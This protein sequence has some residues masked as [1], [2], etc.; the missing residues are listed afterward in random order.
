MTQTDVPPAPAGPAGPWTDAARMA[1]LISHRLADPDL[2]ATA[3]RTSEQA[4]RYPFA[5]GGAS[6][7]SG[8]AGI[9]LLFRHAARVAGQPAGDWSVL[10]HRELV[11]AVASTAEQPLAE[12]GLAA[13]TA[14]LALVVVDAARTDHRYSDAA[15]STVDRLVRQVVDG[16]SWRTDDG[17]RDSDY[18]VIVGAAGTLSY[19]GRTLA[20]DDRVEPAVARLVDDLI[21]LCGRGD[22]RPH[23]YIPPRHYPSDDYR[24]AFP[25]GYVNMGLAHGLPGVLAA[26]SI[27]RAGGYRRPGLGT[28]IRE[29]ADYVAGAATFDGHGPVWGTGVAVDAS[30]TELP[31]RPGAAQTAWCYGTPGVA[32]ALLH[33]ATALD[34]DGLRRRA[35]DAFASVLTRF[36]D[37][38]TIPSATL[39]HGAAGLLMICAM[40]AEEGDATA[41]AALPALTGHLLTHCDPELPLGVR[42]LEQPGV[43]LDSPGLLSGAAGVALALW[44][45]GAAADRDW[46]HA[47]LLA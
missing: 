17:V 29:L 22:G 39:C 16:P 10:A 43:L 9:S 40:F 47:L 2:V 15:R 20:T 37:R 41:V 26:L 6:L 42:D 12:S 4:A 31:P 35:T 18:D 7:Y 30:G 23:A 13:G 27:A 38:P 28:L 45:V 5:W 8:P 24:H 11:R 44:T 32:V 1:E 21:W 33:A 25:D 36:A 14:G 3:V 19:L 46:L 34:D